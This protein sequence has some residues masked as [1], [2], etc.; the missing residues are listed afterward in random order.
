MSDRVAGVVLAAGVSSRMGTN[1]LFLEL[2][3]ITVLRRAVSS[4][5][6]AAL[7]PVLVVVGAGRHRI[8][9]ELSGVD[10]TLIDNVEY[11]A[12]INTS[13]RAGIGAVPDDCA[14]A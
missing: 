7:D 2:G 6:G 11:G 1:K 9:S 3:G 5:L 8:E 14:A 4:A 13:L 10:C 12:G